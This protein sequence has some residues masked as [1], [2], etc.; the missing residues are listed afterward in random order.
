[1]ARA[2]CSPRCPRRWSPTSCDKNFGLYRDRVGALYVYAQ[3]AAQLG[4]ALSNGHTLARS[5]WSM[6][7]DHGAAAVR[8]V[9]DDPDADRAMARRARPDA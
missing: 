7:P 8:L 4:R 5:A 1:M 2:R 3:D 6:P 9:L